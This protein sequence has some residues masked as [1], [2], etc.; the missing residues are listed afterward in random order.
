MSNPPSRHN[1]DLLLDQRRRRWIN[2]KPTLI[3]QRFVP[4]L[5]L[6]SDVLAPSQRCHMLA[7]II[8]TLA[9][10]CVTRRLPLAGDSGWKQ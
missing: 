8:P 7:S 3:L 5:P 10:I 4:A 9:D 1:V 2:V 6:Q